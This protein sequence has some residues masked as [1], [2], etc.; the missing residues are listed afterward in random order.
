[1]R[2]LCGEPCGA[3]VPLPALVPAAALR[4]SGSRR[5]GQVSPCRGHEE[6]GSIQRMTGRHQHPRSSLVAAIST[7]QGVAGYTLNPKV[8]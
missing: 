1:M 4:R 7:N 6:Q 5:R 3:R 2:G 8:F